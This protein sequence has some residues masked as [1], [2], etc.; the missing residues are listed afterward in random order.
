MKSKILATIMLGMICFPIY[1]FQKTFHYD[2]SALIFANDTINS[3]IYSNII[4][5][6]NFNVLDDE[7]YIGHP[8]LPVFH[9]SMTIADNTIVD[10]VHVVLSN[11]TSGILTYPLRPIQP[12]VVIGSFIEKHSFAFDENVY[13]TDATIPSNNLLNYSVDQ[14]RDGKFLSMAIIPFRYNPVTNEYTAYSDAEVEIYTHEEKH[15]IKSNTRSNNIGIPFYEYVIVTSPQLLSA[16]EPFA[17]WKRAKG[18]NVGIVS[19]ND[20]LN[21]PNL[22]NGD[23]ISNINDDAGKLRQYFIHSYDS[24]QTQYA[25][26]AGDSSII[27]IRYGYGKCITTYTSTPSDFYYSELNSNW[28]ENNNG[29][30]GEEA[31]NVDYGAEIYVGRLL[32]SSTDEVTNWTKKV[33]QYEINPGN[34]NYAYLGRAL[35]SQ[36]D[37]LQKSQL[38][39]SVKRKLEKDSINRV[40]YI[41]CTILNEYPSYNYPTPTAPLGNDI[42]DSI[43]N[44]H[45]GI[46]GNFNHGGPLSYGV[47]THGVGDYGPNY[48]HV[49][50]AMDSY[51]SGFWAYSSIVD[52]GNG[53][54]NL[55]NSVY[56][57]IFYS[58]S[59]K[60]MPF[61]MFEMYEDTYN[62]GRIFTCRSEG[63][64][65]A[66]L[67]NTRD[68]ITTSSTSLFKYFIDSIFVNI[69]NNHL[70]IAEAKSK[71]C[72]H[73]NYMRHVHNL[74]GCP[75]MSLYTRVPS[76]FENLIVNQTENHMI[77]SAGADSIESRICLSGYINNVYRQFVY[78]N[79]S[80]VQF[81]TIPETYTL[82]V[83][84]PNYIPYIHTNDTCFLQNSTI[85]DSRTYGGCSTFCIGSDISPLQPY[86][87]ITIENGG[88]ATINVGDKVV[89]KND[90]EVKL[91]GTLDI[92]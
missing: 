59:C 89:I 78:T 5:L 33:L 65:P 77:V 90:F 38:A 21:N 70:G 56:P 61:D 52:Y 42:I 88:S 2:T 9:H 10:S 41:N 20:I 87:N 35:F 67:G 79:R 17:H 73:V 66:Y 62:L 46:L 84:K 3:A 54:D 68:G 14:A 44:I 60:N 15:H 64:G 53:F 58:V 92:R 25:L 45:Y 37:Q 27:P 13:G 76:T 31:D 80:N 82:V 86:G 18:Y 55:T 83:S 22:A 48:H 6:D 47:A 7:E 24:I 49:I 43:N 72:S 71:F 30:Y 8:E 23:E 36:T 91:G 81:D 34:G 11:E 40:N 50:C 4:W 69:H 75:E 16:F 57:A 28:D 26:L 29:I 63:G 74:L 39:E 51:D 12:P 1:A 85:S 32:C 19:I